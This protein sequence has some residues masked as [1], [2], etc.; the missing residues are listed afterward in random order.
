MKTQTYSL[1]T[2]PMSFQAPVWSRGNAGMNS[3]R[4]VLEDNS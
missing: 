1:L 4:R 2:E 3:I